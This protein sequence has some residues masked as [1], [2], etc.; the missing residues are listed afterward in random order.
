MLI[1]RHAHFRLSDRSV[2]KTS[3]LEIDE[4]KLLQL[5]QIDSF[6]AEIKLLDSDK[7]LRTSSRIAVYFPFIG[8]NGLLRSTGRIRPLVET[9][10]EA[11]HE[12]QSK[13]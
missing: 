6:P 13:A 1:P 7:S 4:A 11:E 8:P 10:F 2:T 3:E 5:S 9:S 12:I